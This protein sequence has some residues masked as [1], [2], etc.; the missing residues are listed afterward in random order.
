[1]EKEKKLRHYKLQPLRG[2]Y[3]VFS[4]NQVLHQLFLTTSWD[5][6][7]TTDRVLVYLTK[8]Q[9]QRTRQGCGPFKVVM[10]AQKGL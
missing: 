9:K 3:K 1:M 2:W 10:S 8:F 7:A 5:L 4:H 6:R